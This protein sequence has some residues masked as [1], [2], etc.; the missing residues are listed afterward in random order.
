[1]KAIK[2]VVEHMNNT[3]DEACEYYDD[4]VKYLTDNPKISSVALE[5]AKTHLDLYNK[6]HNVVVN[7]INDYRAKNQDIPSEMLIIWDYE[8][9]KLVKEYDELKFKIYNID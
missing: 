5:M 3:L 2:T 8:H 4:Y 9:K 1:M 6:W 7:L